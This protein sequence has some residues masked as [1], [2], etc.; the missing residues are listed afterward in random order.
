VTTTCYARFP[1]ING[2]DVVFVADDD[3]WLTSVDGGRAHRITTDRIPVR[4]PRISPDGSRV[5]WT[6][7]RGQQQ[8][9]FVASLDGG[10]ATQLTHWGQG[11]AMVRGWLSA[12]EVIVVSTFGEAARARTVARAV[13]VDGG[14]SRRLPYG[15]V[16]EVA[17]GP[18][19]GALVTTLCFT[20][21]S[22][23]KRYRGGQAPR[24]WLDADGSGDFRR[25]FGAVEAGLVSPLWAVAPDGRQ[26]V[27]FVS[28]QDGPAQLYSAPL[29]RR[30]P[31]WSRAHRHTG[32]DFY[33]RHATSDGLRVV[34][35]CAGDLWVLDGLDP[36][37]EPRPLAVRIAG[38]RSCHAVRRVEVTE[39]LDTVAVDRTG[40]ASALCSRGT[41]QWLP[42]RDGPARALADGSGIRRRLPVV[43]GTTGRVAWVTD[44][45]GDDSIEVIDTS[46][47]AS[48]PRRLVAPGRVGRALEMAAAPDGR[49]LAVATHDGRLLTVEVPAGAVTRTGRIR[50]VDTTA[51]G[52]MS[53][54]TFSPD[55]S[56]LA[57]S[58]PG[59][60]PLR[61]IRICDT[62][63]RSAPINVTALRFTDSDPTFT[64]DGK[65]L[66]FLSVRTLDPVYDA[67]VFDLSFPNGCRPWLVPLD[68]T[69]PA[70]FA[71]RVGGRPAGDTEDQDAPRPRGDST[72]APPRS[73]VDATDIEHRLV[74]MPVDG[75]RYSHLA[76]VDGGLTWLRHPLSGELGGGLPSVDAEPPRPTLEYL[77]FKSGK[78]EVLRKEADSFVATGDGSR[79]VVRDKDELLVVPANRK[80]DDDSPETVTVDL[81]RVRIDVHPLREWAQMYDEAWRLMRD[82]F[83]RPD[84]GGVDWPGVHDRYRPLVQRLGSR[85][86]LI[87]LIWEMHGELGSSHAYCFA[88]RD[89]DDAPRQGL[90]GA[91]VEL[92]DGRWQ[93]TRILPG[94]ASDHRARSPLL[95]PGV[96]VN[97]GDTVVAVDGRQVSATVS[98]YALLV[99]AAGKPVELT[100]S[101]VAGGGD[102]RVAVIPTDD[103]TPL[104]YQDWVRDRRSYVHAQ[105][106]GR[107][108]YLHVPD[109][110][111]LGWAQM[112]RD[113]RTELK[114]DA[115]ILDVREN[116]GGHTSQL[117]L[118]KLVRRVIGWSLSRGYQPVSYPDDARRGPLVAVA[119]MNAGSDGDIITAAVK[120]MGLGPVVGARTWGG[121]IGIDGRY[122]LVDGTI[123]TQPRYAFWFAAQGWGVENHGVDPDVEVIPT[124]RERDT[125]DDV[126]LDRALAIA[127]QRL[128]SDP[129]LRPPTLPDLPSRR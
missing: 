36:A 27:G 17:L 102:R 29:G 43:L 45:D 80:V 10:V 92:V 112:H 34:Y 66:A 68:R 91:D 61:Q 46:D 76:A 72:S 55:S 1:H 94:E 104:R 86:D 26:R 126:Q 21:L 32:H 74:P 7:Q 52:D 51:N 81:S 67:F 56:W 48:Q 33:V 5:A 50:E 40:Q 87:D 16:D 13:P 62:A 19:G 53:G 120:G 65:H 83:W 116:G 96:G 90:L 97:E 103:E 124:P 41:V 69:T 3:I 2:D 125:G 47:V 95:A 108:G 82:H 106:G 49:R 127:A 38:T 128:R 44:E 42:H 111:S 54:L 64:T 89:E 123:V 78:V 99:G 121:V 115:L 70:P 93:L 118:E 20:E 14:P 39:R 84:M 60:E 18:E 129:P 119:D 77:S 79:L 25:L 28:D 98:P 22:W 59:P 100:V 73:E 63:A 75:A 57:W 88:P 71:P 4:S 23:W 113:L 31:S 110:M 15:W 35:M 6:A 9:A 114:R 58:A 117:V 109:M 105:T 8:E 37:V 101:P 24:L 12:D 11:R 30:A 85:D 122:T 107:V